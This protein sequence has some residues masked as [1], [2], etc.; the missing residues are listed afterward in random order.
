MSQKLSEIPASVQD[1]LRAESLYSNEI[2]R[3]TKEVVSILNNSQR[4]LVAL[5]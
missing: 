3:T 2:A 1:C 5:Y 4:T